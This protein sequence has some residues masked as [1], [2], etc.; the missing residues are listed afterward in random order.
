MAVDTQPLRRRPDGDK[1]LL[2]LD[3]S[4]LSD[5]AC[6]PDFSALKD[7]LREGVEADRLLCPWSPE[8][9]AETYGAK[10]WKEIADLGD[11]LS[12]GIS[13]RFDEEI[14]HREIHRAAAEFSSVDPPT[15]IWREAFSEDPHTP[16]EQLYPSG[17]RVRAFLPP[18]EIDEEDR[19]Y[20]RSMEDERMTAAYAQARKEG[21]TFEVRTEQ[22]FE[23]I[24]YW[25][26]GPLTDPN[27]Y[28][29]ELVAKALA[30][31][32]E[33]DAGIVDVATGS[34]Y[35]L[36]TSMSERKIHAEHLIRRYPKVAEDLAGFVG[37]PALRSMP[38]LRYPAFLRAALA[39]TPNRK[40]KQGDG[41]DLSHLM[42]GLSRC[43][44]VTADSG[45]VELVT[46]F[47]LVPTGCRVFRGN[48][49]EGLTAAVREV[50]A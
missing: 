32:K 14:N 35:G 17:L 6:N 49:V 4:T 47:K 24:I 10:R 25:R 45:M 19:T 1:A 40:A 42:K 9:H 44:I 37:S 38:S 41:Y 30:W 23:E 16:R 28:Q 5:L 27:R 22:E 26:L 18:G 48:D 46:G 7:L 29:R 20:T 8:H 36:A 33:A 31:K 21:L 43:D 13:F 11:E 50:L 12:M 39:L 34:A 15:P 3:Q 2:Y